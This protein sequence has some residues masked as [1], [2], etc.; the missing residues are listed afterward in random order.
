[1]AKTTVV[2]KAQ[3]KLPG[4]DVKVSQATI[5]AE[6]YADIQDDIAS[7]KALLQAQSEKVVVEMRKAGQRVLNFTDER[8][9]K[10]TFAI[11]EGVTKLRHSKRE[12]E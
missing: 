1:M 2:E 12:E 3:P 6:R 7:K 10:H 11:I 5:E 4:A 9:Y 8:G